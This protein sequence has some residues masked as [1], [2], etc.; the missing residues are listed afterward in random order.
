MATSQ[1][2]G[3]TTGT[4]HAYGLL[5]IQG[6]GGPGCS[7]FTH[8]VTG[9]GIRLNTLFAQHARHNH[10]HREQQRL[11]DCRVVHARGSWLC[12]QLLQQRETRQGLHHRIQLGQQSRE[13]RGLA[14]Q[15]HTHAQ[16]L[17][18]VAGVHKGQLTF[19][20]QGIYGLQTLRILSLGVSTQL[21][22][23]FCDRFG[24]NDQSTR[25]SLTTMSDCIAD[26]VKIL[27]GLV[28]Q[29]IR[30]IT[31]LLAQSAFCLGRQDQRR[32]IRVRHNS[33]LSRHRYGSL[34]Q[35]VRV[36]TAKA[37]R[38]QARHQRLAVGALQLPALGQQ[39]QIQAIKIN[40]GIGGV[41]M[42]SRRQGLMLQSQNGLDQTGHP[43]GRL[44]MPQVCFDRTD[45]QTLF[46]R[47][48]IHRTD[49]GGF[50]RVTYCRTGAVS[51]YKVHITRSQAT[52]LQHGAHQLNLSLATRNGDA[53]LAG[54]IGIHAGCQNDSL[55]LITIGQGLLQ[56]LEHQ[57]STAL[58]TDIAITG[59]IERLAAA[60]CR[61][62]R[63]F[64]K[65][66]KGIRVQQ[67]IDAT[68]QSGGRL[69]IAQT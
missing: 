5:Q 13:T 21:C 29:Q 60:I 52:A 22:H 12:L 15:G 61:Q 11:G 3:L 35:D 32:Q 48:S 41:Q 20:I 33:R 62:H 49:C 38:I 28:I 53:G 36:G 66:H 16:P 56:G 2:L 18:S 40:R 50:D 34:Q 8:T 25:Q 27:R 46:A 58:G 57:D 31:S 42:Q 68:D 69:A 45:R 1:T 7:D 14:Q 17:R 55:Y 64:G 51:L 6:T 47:F 44:H 43:R 4:N 24:L 10:L 39:F 23:A 54:T 59:F 67:Q 26:I 30:V 65:A 37:K 9:H 19:L 63:R